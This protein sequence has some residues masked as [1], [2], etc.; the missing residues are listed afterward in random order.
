MR[1]RLDVTRAC[2]TRSAPGSFLGALLA[3][4]GRAQTVTSASHDS[5]AVLRGRVIKI[6]GGA[7][8]VGAA[9]WV[10]STDRH[11]STDSTGAFHVEGLRAGLMLLEVRRLGYDVRRDTVM[12][13]PSHDNVRT[14]ALSTASATLDTVRTLAQGGLSPR[15]RAFDERMQT[16]FGHFI[17]DSVFR[18]NENSSVAERTARRVL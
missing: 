8:I 9:G 3:V 6:D 1:L 12:L 14:Y 10:I 2:A 11:A 18:R 4:V 13:S 16:G 7:P 15:T 5:T 17:T